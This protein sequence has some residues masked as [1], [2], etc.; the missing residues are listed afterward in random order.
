MIKKKFKIRVKFDYYY[1]N[2]SWYKVQYKNNLISIWKDIYEFDLYG[3]EP[4]FST[5]LFN[6]HASAVNFAKRFKNINDIKKYNKEEQN[7]Y[8]DW[9]KHQIYL[10]NKNKP[11]EKI[12]NIK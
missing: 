10:W 12:T 1:N 4:E 6:D 2:K 7:K 9:K 11:K 8:K 3:N 5:I